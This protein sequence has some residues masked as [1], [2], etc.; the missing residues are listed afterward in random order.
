[1][2]SFNHI[3]KDSKI[4]PQLTGN[5]CWQYLREEVLAEANA[6]EKKKKFEKMNQHWRPYNALCAFCSF[7]YT[8]ISKTE[9]FDEDEM[10][11]MEMFGLT[12]RKQSK[13]NTNAED[14][15]QNITKQC[16]ERYRVVFGLHEFRLWFIL[17]CI[18][19][20]KY[21]AHSEK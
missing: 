14:K 6:S 3:S 19:Q 10:R 7:N 21:G 15:K 12:G 20:L 9:T 5:N 13:L 2:S 8:V 1:M 16:F 17:I 4:F 11:I 18:T